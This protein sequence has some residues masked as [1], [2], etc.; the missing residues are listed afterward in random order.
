MPAPKNVKRLIVE[1]SGWKEKK[2]GVSCVTDYERTIKF[3]VDPMP[4]EDMKNVM[5]WLHKDGCPG[6]TGVRATK[7][8]HASATWTFTTTM[9]SSG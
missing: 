4:T 1:D 3:N 2:T 6:W 9:D 7:Q 8:V 5:D